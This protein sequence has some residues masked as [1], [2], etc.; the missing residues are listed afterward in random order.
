M[1]V[2]SKAAVNKMSVVRFPKQRSRRL[3][4]AEDSFDD[5][6]PELDA[7]GESI[8]DRG[9]DEFG[10]PYP[11]AACP[12]PFETSFERKPRRKA[13]R[14]SAAEIIARSMSPSSRAGDMASLP[15]ASEIMAQA[16]CPPGHGFS[17][18]LLSQSFWQL[19]LQH[20]DYLK[21]KAFIF[22]I[23]TARTPRTR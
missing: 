11:G 18:E 1:S 19:W 5:T 23:G 13:R 15:T 22:S 20:Q 3:L 10:F 2:A 14:P 7:D 6:S 9:E 12:R 8:P 4:A 21:K 17:S 16:L